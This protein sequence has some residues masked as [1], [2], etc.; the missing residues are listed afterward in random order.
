MSASVPKNAP[1]SLRWGA[2]R[3]HHDLIVE[4]LERGLSYGEIAEKASLVGGKDQIKATAVMN[5][6]GR[7]GLKQLSPLYR[8]PNVGR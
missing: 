6:A 8:R 4:G 2:L 3:Q 7:Y 1:Y 5:Y